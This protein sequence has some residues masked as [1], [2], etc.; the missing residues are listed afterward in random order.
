MKLREPGMPDEPIWSGFFSPAQRLTKL[1][2]TGPGRIVS[3]RI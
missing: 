2:L 1:G 3:E